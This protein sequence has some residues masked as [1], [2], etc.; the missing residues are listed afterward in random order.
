M[1]NTSTPAER[2][3]PDAPRPHSSRRPTTAALAGL[4]AVVLLVALAHGPTVPASASATEPE[5]T[6]P[7][8]SQ[9]LSSKYVARQIFHPPCRWVHV[10]VRRQT[11]DPR[12]V[13][14]ALFPCSVVIRRSDYTFLRICALIVHEY[15]HLAGREHSTDLTD[16]MHP[17]R[18]ARYPPCVEQQ[19]SMRA[20]LSKRRRARAAR[21]RHNRHKARRRD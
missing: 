13:G 3:L 6:G 16:I 20:S 17:A 2:K 15:G 1:A 5:G 18:P 9:V 10:M 8:L 19:R 21:H 12:Y 7:T 4:A 11:P 14:E